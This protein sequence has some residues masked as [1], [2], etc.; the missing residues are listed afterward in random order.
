[1]ARLRN[2]NPGI[3]FLIQLWSKYCMLEN[4][5]LEWAKKHIRCSTELKKNHLLYFQGESKKEVYL[6]IKGLIGRVI[7]DN[8]TSKRRILSV[9]TPGMGF[10]TTNHLYSSTPSKG[11]IIALRSGTKV[12]QLTYRSILELMEMDRNAD[13]LINVLTNK[14]KK[15]LAALRR[16]SLEGSA[17]EKC[18]LFAE[19]L[20]HLYLI[21]SQ[22][23]I[24]DILNISRRTVQMA[25]GYLARNP[26][27]K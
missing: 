18:I 20:P 14:K 10:M 23:E 19:E 21:L 22:Q 2:N 24:A 3:R 6:V 27:K 25:S 7:E 5:H 13:I 15:Q 26:I 8:E 11:A 17:L 1:M 4:F 12:I 9:G 16:I